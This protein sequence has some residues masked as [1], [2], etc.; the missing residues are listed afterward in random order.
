MRKAEQFES[1]PIRDLLARALSPFGIDDDRRFKMDGP[2]IRL[3]PR[4]ILAF[5]L[6]LHELAT[7]ATKYGALSTGDGA[8]HI[9]WKIVDGQLHLS[10]TEKGGRTVEE[11][12]RVGFGTQLI[13]RVLVREKG[14]TVKLSY[15][16]EGFRFLAVAP[17][18]D[19]AET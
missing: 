18:L 3:S 4:L 2:N 19:L 1:A 12:T 14:G 15:E 8:V 16:P 11:P 10:W 17:L 13:R 5:A 7:N 6:T 9:D